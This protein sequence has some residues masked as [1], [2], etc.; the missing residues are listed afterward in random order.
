MMPR[1]VSESSWPVGSS[2]ISTCGRLARARAIATRCCSPPDSSYGRWSMRSPSPTMVQQLATRVLAGA[3]LGLHQPQRNLDVL[4]GRQDR[5][6]AQRLEHETDPVSAELDQL[7]LAELGDCLAVDHDV[8]SVGRS[9]PPMIDSSVVLPHPDR[10][11]RASSLARGTRRLTSTE[12]A[13]RLGAGLVDADELDRLDHRR[14]DFG[15]PLG[16]HV[17]DVESVRRASVMVLPVLVVAGSPSGQIEMWSPSSTRARG[18]PGPAP[19]LAARQLQPADAIEHGVFLG[20]QLVLAI[21]RDSGARRSV[22]VLVRPSR[23]AIV[24]CTWLFTSGSWVTTTIVTPSSLVGA[25]HD[26]EDVVRGDR[27]ELA[28]RLVGEQHR[29]PVGQRDRDRDALLLAARQ[30]VGPAVGVTRSDISSSISVNRAWRSPPADA[31]EDHRQL[32]V[33]AHVEVWQQVARRLLADEADDL[34]PV[35]GQLGA[36]HLAQDV[37]GH[38]CASGRRHVET[39]EDVHQR[40]LAAARGADD[41]DELAGVDG[42]FEALKRD[43]LEVRRPCRSSPGRGTR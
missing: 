26:A 15:A 11:R 37:S 7:V 43:H 23:M 28:G 10:P 1:P 34:P 13:Y 24:R 9:S 12:G 18:A 27:V 30:L 41:G 42:Q 25:P 29:R 19:R 32:D 4:R 36:A 31:V 22:S 3:G 6:Q 21:D 16:R 17:L 5:Q 2:A 35:G 14:L 8:P 40:A 20:D 39:A 33:L 38:H